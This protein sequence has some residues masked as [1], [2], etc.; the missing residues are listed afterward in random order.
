MDGSRARPIILRS[1]TS[2][3]ARARRRYI[4]GDDRLSSPSPS[5][6]PVTCLGRSHRHIKYEYDPAA[7][8]AAAG[9]R[10]GRSETAH[11]HTRPTHFNRS[12]S[13]GRRKLHSASRIQSTGTR[14]RGSTNITARSITLF[15]RTSPCGRTGT[16]RPTAAA[17]R[18]KNRGRQPYGDRRQRRR[19]LHPR[20][21]SV[22]GVG[23]CLRRRRRRNMEIM[24]IYGTA[25]A[26][27]RHEAVMEE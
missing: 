20:A 4:N 16:A 21:R 19:R 13:T 15:Q 17:A 27:G 23:R 8:V 24:L 22:L 14:A 25:I 11:T 10:L 9:R 26:S 3:A 12:T 2:G 7:A 1:A 18:R 6:P 5:L